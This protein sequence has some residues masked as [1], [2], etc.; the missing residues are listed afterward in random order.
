M[1]ALWTVQA[2]RLNAFGCDAAFRIEPSFYIGPDHGMTALD[3]E[4]SRLPLPSP[5]LARRL[6]FQ[7]TTAELLGQEDKLVEHYRRLVAIAA[8]HGKTASLRPFPYFRIQP[9]I[10]SED[11]LLT[12]FSWNDDLHETQTVLE[13]LAGCASGAPRLLHDDQDQGWRILIA[14]TETATCFIEWDGEG[15][16]PAEGGYAV[17]TVALALQAKTAL[18]RLGIIHD[19]LMRALGKDYWTYRRS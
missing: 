3:T 1:D 6:P 10:L 14:V 8:T 2:R 12:A 5:D 15:P 18:E 13:I 11:Q 16:P 4:V 7:V 19:R 17:D 9:V